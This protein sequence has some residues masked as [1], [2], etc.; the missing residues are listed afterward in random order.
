MTICSW[1]EV[2]VSCYIDLGLKVVTKDP[3][4]FSLHDQ[5]HK[6]L[7]LDSG[8]LMAVLNKTY[9]LPGD[10]LGCLPSGAQLG[11]WDTSSLGRAQGPLGM[12]W[13]DG[14]VDW[15]PDSKEVSLGLG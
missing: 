1:C 10:A 6:V 7:V 15:G 14:R 2:L 5:N 11:L 3:E 8:T 13:W 9:I 12:E 4:K